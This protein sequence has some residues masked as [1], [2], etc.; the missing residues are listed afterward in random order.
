MSNSASRTFEEVGLTR[1]PADVFVKKSFEAVLRPFAV[2]PDIL[3]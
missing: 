1:S 3:I 2:P